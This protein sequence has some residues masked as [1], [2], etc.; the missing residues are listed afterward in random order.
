VIP[1]S[2]KKCFLRTLA[3]Q[4]EFFEWNTESILWIEIFEWNTESILWMFK[5]GY[6]STDLVDMLDI[7]KGKGANVQD[8][9][10]SIFQSNDKEEDHNDSFIHH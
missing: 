1:A 4:N 9:L 8:W 7:L 3:V 5:S 10:I 6:N 2:G